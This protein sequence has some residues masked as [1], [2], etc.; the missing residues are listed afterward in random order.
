MLRVASRLTVTVPGQDR[1]AQL[2]EST[3][4]LPRED[5]IQLALATWTL[6]ARKAL[7][8][9]IGNRDDENEDYNPLK[10]IDE[11]DADR[12]FLR[13]ELKTAELE[14]ALLERRNG[15]RESRFRILSAK[16]LEPILAA[17]R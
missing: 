4:R 6:G 5:A 17:Y 10:V 9:R 16:E 3:E 12:V 1:L 13:D 2:G 7:E 14:I 8:R 11:A 15:G